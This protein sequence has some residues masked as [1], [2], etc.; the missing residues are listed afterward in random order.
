MALR[1]WTLA[2]TIT[3]GMTLLISSF[4]SVF[5]HNFTPNESASFL[6]L[7][8]QIKS[9][10]ITV[11]Q[12][13]S[14]NNGLAREQA[15]YARMLLNDSVLKEL[16]ERNQRIASELPRMLD[17]LQNLSSKDFDNNLGTIDDLLGEAVT[18]RVD[19]DQLTNSTVQALAFA[20]DIDSILD[21]Y[22]AGFNGS[23]VPMN[24]NMNM[25]GMSSI[26]TNVNNS[27]STTLNVSDSEIVKNISAYMRASALT[28]IAIDR[29]NTELKGKSNFT[30]AMEEVV[31]GLD[32]LK[33]SMQNK[34]S[35]TRVMGIV[36]G[37]IQPNLQTAFDLELVPSMKQGTGN[38]S[39]PMSNM[40]N[41]MQNDMMNMS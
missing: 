22:I 7:V 12:D 6:S 21:E 15:Q 30:S 8:D 9:V 4:N 20:T 18:V 28:D 14:S 41:S 40:N 3:I 16:K 23:S 37:Q 2:L 33:I 31:K 19:K 5:P 32:Q 38:M 11:K 36:H 25:I 26:D 24:M 1:L 39:S 13:N 17:A 27:L 35:P 10:L 29:F 34:E